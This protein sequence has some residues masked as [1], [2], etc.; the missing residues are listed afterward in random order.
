MSERLTAKELATALRVK[1]CTIRAWQRTGIPYQ[2]CGR[3]R[4]YSLTAVETWLRDRE[5]HRLARQESTRSDA[6]V[7]GMEA[8]R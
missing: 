1:I 2:P 5:A 3:L 8:G 6:T 7:G 4:F